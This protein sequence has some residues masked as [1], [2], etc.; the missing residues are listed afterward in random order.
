MNKIIKA[1]ITSA[2]LLWSISAT[3]VDIKDIR[4]GATEDQTR[5]VFDL[6]GALEYNVFTLTDPHRIVIDVWD[7]KVSANIPKK[8]GPDLHRIRFARK[9]KEVTRIVLDT[10]PDIWETHF[11]LPASAVAGNRLVVDLKKA[12]HTSA[13]EELL[14]SRPFIIAVDAGHGGKDPGAIGKSYGT[15]EKEVTLAIAKKL[16]NKIDSTPNR[17]ALMV[18]KSDHTMGLR[19][20]TEYARSKG[21]DLFV[22]IHAD[23]F[24]DPSVEGASVYILSEKGASSEAARWI[25]DSENEDSARIGGVLINGKHD[26][27]ASVLLDLSQ[28]VTRTASAELANNILA[29]L[30]KGIP[31]HKKAIES[32]GFVVLKSPDIPS[33]L[34]ETGFLSSKSGE[35]RLRSARKQ[36]EIAM[37]IYDGLEEYLAGRAL[38]FVQDES[39]W[40]L[41]QRQYIVLSGDTLSELAEHFRVSVESIQR[42]NQLKNDG[43]RI[44]QVLMIPGAQG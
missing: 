6:S 14:I 15:L 25:A 33:V 41:E 18:R 5:V 38:P 23:S 16:A 30:K 11:E 29:Q 35:K 17:Q 13:D 2:T 37:A 24:V 28:N 9:S 32:A 8:L 36:Y 4:V 12:H 19:E 40:V 26:I 34:V 42:E 31:I 3:A 7:A 39:R 1:I 44:G 10:A 22:S 20:R 27:L 21:A 43:I